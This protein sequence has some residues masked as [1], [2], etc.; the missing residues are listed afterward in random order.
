MEPLAVAFGSIPLPS[1]LSYRAARLPSQAYR[2]TVHGRA[3]N[4][5]DATITDGALRV[6]VRKWA[7]GVGAPV[8]ES[9][10][11]VVKVFSATKARDRDQ[12]GDRVAAWL[13]ANPHLEIR[14]TV[15]SLSSDSEFHCLS[16]VLICAERR[17]R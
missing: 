9:P 12:L 14:K 17:G 7:D 8:T 16:L 5:S 15:V 10:I 4:S 11:S 3:A 1:F 13:E 2:S 6:G